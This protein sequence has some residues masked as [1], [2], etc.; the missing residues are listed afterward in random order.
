MIVVADTAPINYL[1]LIGEQELLPTL[2][3]RV[4]IPEAVLQELLAVASPQA[5]REWIAKPPQWIEIRKSAMAPDRSLSHL[6]EGERQALQLAEELRAN[7]FLVDEKA[8][9]REA[10]KRHLET[11]GTL[12][13]LDRAAE[14]RLVDFSQ[15]F[16]RLKQ[17]SFYMSLAVERFFLEREQ[18]RK[19]SRR[20][21]PG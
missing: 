1:V 20:K 11:S 18:Q 5:V 21:P 2:F 15:A 6:D 13:V 14:K 9:R 12:G 7:L 16:R 19:A 8:A 4:I 17:T 10:V 3:G